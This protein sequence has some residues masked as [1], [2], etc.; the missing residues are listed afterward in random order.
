MANDDK[1]TKTAMETATPN[2]QKSSTEPAKPPMPKTESVSA[3]PAKANTTDLSA[4]VAGSMGGKFV[5][6]GGGKK[7]RLNEQSTS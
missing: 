2:L 5:A 3:S 7:R 6:L 1:V 4:E